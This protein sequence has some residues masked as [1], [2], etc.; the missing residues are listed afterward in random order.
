MWLS[1]FLFLFLLLFVFL[2]EVIIRPIFLGVAETEAI[3]IANKAIYQV[4]KEEAYL[5]DYG[6]LINYRENSAGEIVMLQVNHHQVSKLISKVTL[7]LQ[8]KLEEIG[9]E[10]LSLPLAQLF[11]IQVLAGFGPQIKVKLLPLGI[12][13]ATNIH[14]KFEAVGINQTRHRI[15]LELNPRI[16]V[17]VPFMEK[18]VEVRAQVPVTEVTIMGRVPEFYLY[19]DRGLI[20]ADP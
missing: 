15:Y 11:G 6:D 14:D 17:V 18:V 19:M 3:K 20:G 1:L 10:G 8:E 12:A 9:E 13:D 16:R 7:S 2:V 5:L 4:V